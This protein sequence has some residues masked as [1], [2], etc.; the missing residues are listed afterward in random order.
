MIFLLNNIE[1][2]CCA[3]QQ[4]ENIMPFIEK[5]KRKFGD[6]VDGH[7]VK[8]APGMNVIM[9]GLYPNR[10]D[11]EVSA[12][13]ELDVTNL[14]KYIKKRNEEHP[15]EIIKFYPY[16]LTALVRVANERR[17]L[18][19]FIRHYRIYERDEISISFTAKRKFDDNA[20]EVVVTYKAR[21][22]DNVSSINKFLNGEYKILRAEE[23]AST[24]PVDNSRKI[25]IAS[26]YISAL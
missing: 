14:V 21:K 16:F 13:M 24:L 25:A 20:K 18:N 9:T 8:D 5:R 11:C 7:W 2:V 19:R 17:C 4:K 3:R 26:S 15:D 23:E 22:E 6:R 10:T 12:K 1:Y